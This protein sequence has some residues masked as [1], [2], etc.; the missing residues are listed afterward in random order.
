[1]NRESGRLCW[2]FKPERSGQER[3]DRMK[4]AVFIINSL[5]LGGAERVV[6]TQAEF[7][8]KSGIDVTIICFR[9][10]DQ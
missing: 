6:V 2:S 7:L 9:K 4:K 1:M 3:K 8:Q 5:Q 10:R